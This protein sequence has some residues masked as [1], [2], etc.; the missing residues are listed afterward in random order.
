MKLK[1]SREAYGK[2]LNSKLQQN[3]IKDG[4]SGMKTI[5]GLKAKGLKTEGNLERAN[6][7]YVLCYF[8]QQVQHRTL[9]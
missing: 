6:E 5:T 9:K 1:E 2:K 3:N 7:L 8:F 4:K